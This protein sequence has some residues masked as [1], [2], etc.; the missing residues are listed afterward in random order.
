MG[1]LSDKELIAEISRRFEEKE[2]SIKDME[3]MT[4]K[5]LVLNE[6]TKEAEAAKSKFLSLIKNEFNNPISTLL[7]MSK[8]LVEKKNMDRFDEIADMMNQELL[9]LDFHLK[10][11]FCASEI[12]AGEIANDYST[13]DVKSIYDEVIPS[14]KYIIKD[15]DLKV[16]FEIEAKSQFVSD[17]QKFYMIMLNIVSNACEF[18][19]PKKDVNISFKEG[20]E[21]FYLE[22]EDFGEGIFVEEKKEIYNRFTQFHSGETR[23][24][25]GLGLGLSVAREFAEALDGD[26][27]Y[28]STKGHTVFTITFPKLDSKNISKSIG[29][30]EFLFDEFEES[31]EM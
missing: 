11:I 20:P 10:N 2:A 30:N 27:F 29:A 6:K 24:Y 17:A 12:E 21:H 31:L 19:Y 7:S 14:F 23:P 1:N 15:K 3:I 4:K 13:I 16:N 9:R 25:S 28:T 26:I 22:V 8:K 5:L 18:S